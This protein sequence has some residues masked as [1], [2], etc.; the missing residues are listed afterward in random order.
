MPKNR[1]HYTSDNVHILSEKEK[2]PKVEEYNK[3]T[4][5]SACNIKTDK[6]EMRYCKTRYCN[7]SDEIN[8]FCVI[9][10][11][12]FNKGDYFNHRNKDQHIL[13][14]LCYIGNR[15]IEEIKKNK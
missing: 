14:T 9:C 3:P 10:D 8:W 11:K 6:L 7:S 15:V 4:E 5:C 2:K 12:V 1:R 13:S